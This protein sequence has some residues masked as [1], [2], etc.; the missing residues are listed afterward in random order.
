MHNIYPRCSLCRNTP[1]NGLYDGFRLAGKFICSACEEQ[2]MTADV[3]TPK[4]Q[5]NLL[6]IRKVLYGQSA[7]YICGQSNR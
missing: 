7:D 6:L 3:R 4:Y 2:I 5:E 1:L